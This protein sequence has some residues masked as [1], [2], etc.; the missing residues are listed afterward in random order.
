MQHP[1]LLKALK[2]EVAEWLTKIS[3]YKQPLFQRI[4]G[5]QMLHLYFKKSLG[6]IQV[7]IDH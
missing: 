6:V 1:R 2:Y 4:G 5:L 7:N 3:H